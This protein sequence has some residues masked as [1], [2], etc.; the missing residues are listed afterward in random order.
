MYAS[1]K[2]LQASKEGKIFCKYL[3]C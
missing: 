1:T 3:R 2:P